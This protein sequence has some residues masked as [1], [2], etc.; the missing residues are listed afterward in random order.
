MFTESCKAYSE[1]VR[2]GADFRYAKFLKRT[3]RLWRERAVWKIHIADCRAR[4]TKHYRFVHQSKYL[5]SVKF[6]LYVEK[7]AMRKALRALRRLQMKITLHQ[8]LGKAFGVVE[9]QWEEF[10]HFMFLTTQATRVQAWW[11]GWVSSC[12]DFGSGVCAPPRKQPS[13]VSGFM[14]PSSSCC[15]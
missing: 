2:R 9:T 15:R 6:S 5:A 14:V 8:W 13:Q 10:E 4:A 7:R 3:M 11:R 12:V 1:L